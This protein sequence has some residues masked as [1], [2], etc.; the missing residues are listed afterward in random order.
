ANPPDRLR[1][2]VKLVTWYRL[3]E[4]DVDDDFGG[5][6]DF[7]RIIIVTA[8]TRIALCSRQCRPQ[9][10]LAARMLRS[11]RRAQQRVVVALRELLLHLLT[12]SPV[13][14]PVEY[15]HQQYK[16]DAQQ[17]QTD[18]QI[19]HCQPRIK[20]WLGSRIATVSGSLR[21]H[22]CERSRYCFMLALHSSLG[23]LHGR[24]NVYRNDTRDAL[25]LHRN[26]DELLGHLHGNLV[27]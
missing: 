16:N 2:G 26:A 24:F 7:S 9:S 25:F 18:L 27:M 13:L 12:H 21:T 10:R 8:G 5:G 3:R 1:S 14:P 20:A 11:G 15:Q 22:L 19:T 6:I 4:A 23:K 17:D